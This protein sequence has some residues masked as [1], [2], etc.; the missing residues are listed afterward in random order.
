M[1]SL[2]FNS[3]YLKLLLSQTKN[4]QEYGAA[5]SSTALLLLKKNHH[6]TGEIL[7]FLSRKTAIKMRKDITSKFA[8]LYDIS[9]KIN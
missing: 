8:L 2:Y 4:S 3:F 9:L 6:K 5:L 7:V 1:Y